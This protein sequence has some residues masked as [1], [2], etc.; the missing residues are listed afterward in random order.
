VFVEGLIGEQKKPILFE[1]TEPSSVPYRAPPA[2]AKMAAVMAE[3]SPEA[4]GTATDCDGC[5]RNRCV[6]RVA[7]SAGEY[8]EV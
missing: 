3:V 1:V 6:T 2:C 4:N 5:F 8:M 7:A